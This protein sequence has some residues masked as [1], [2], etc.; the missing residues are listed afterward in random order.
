M[1]TVRRGKSVASP[2]SP[3]FWKEV[4]I[5]EKKEINQILIMNSKS[6]FKIYFCNFY[7]STV[8]KNGLNG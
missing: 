7:A 3:D 1:T 4:E 5:E 6:I 2:P 8:S